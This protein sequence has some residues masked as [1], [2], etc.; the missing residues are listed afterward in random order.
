M[1]P[2]LKNRESRFKIKVFN[3]L[4]EIK[5]SIYFIFKSFTNMNSF[6]L[7]VIREFHF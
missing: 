6:L 7:F 5:V 4:Y 3:Y 2:K 1:Y